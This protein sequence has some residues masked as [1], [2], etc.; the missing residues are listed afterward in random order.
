MSYD[1]RE[2]RTSL[3]SALDELD[4]GSLPLESVI[5]RGKSVV[6]RRRLTAVAGALVIAIAAVVSP[7]IVH[8]IGHSARPATPAPYHITVHAPDPKS[9]PGLI[10]YGR[11]NHRRWHVTGSAER[12]AGGMSV[13]FKA[14]GDACEQMPIPLPTGKDAPAEFTVTVGERPMVLIGDVRAD[15]RYVRVSLNNGQTVTLRPVAVFGRAHA[16]WIALMV[17]YAAA[18]T[19]ITAYSATGELGYAIPFARGPQFSTVRW[20]APGQIPPAKRSTYKI[21]SGEVN[22]RPWSEY[23]YL[24][25]WGTCV[26]GAGHGGKCVVGGLDQLGEGKPASLLIL[27]LARHSTSY[28][29]IVAKP[30]VSYVIVHFKNAAPLRVPTVSKGGVKF[31]GFAAVPPDAPVRWVAYSASGQVLASGRLG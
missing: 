23:A 31:A 24:G 14:I 15:V 22:G 16:S 30:T 18:V 17:P 3:G 12:F 21:A 1:E 28:G 5:S 8:Q 26:T 27:S 13:C 6:L 19:T 9:T 2:L 7:V 25:P 10:A 4:Y 11:L 29:V 20:F